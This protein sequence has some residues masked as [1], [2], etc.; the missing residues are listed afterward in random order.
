MTRGRWRAPR[1][2][3][4]VLLMMVSVS[5]SAAP[6]SAHVRVFIGG[7]FGTPVYAYPRAYVHP[8]PTYYTPDAGCHGALP[9][10]WVR[11]HWVRERDAWGRWIQVWVA[12]H[13]R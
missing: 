11:G 9:P 4:A 7:V 8:Y 10:G 12:A 5:A 3:F 13:L 2:I 6:A 1:W